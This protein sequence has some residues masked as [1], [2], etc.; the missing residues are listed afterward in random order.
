[1]GIV[2][3]NQE[4]LYFNKDWELAK[5]QNIPM[6]KRNIRDEKYDTFVSYNSQDYDN[7]LVD[8][9]NNIFKQ[10]NIKTYIDH[11]CNRKFDTNDTQEVKALKDFLMETVVCIPYF[12]ILMTDKVASQYVSWSLAEYSY[13][14][15]SCYLS[16]D[17]KK[18]LIPIIYLIQEGNEIFD[19]PDIFRDGHT[20]T[21][22]YEL[23]NVCK[24]IQNKKSLKP[25]ISSNIMD[26]SGTGDIGDNL[27][28]RSKSI[29]R[30]REDSITSGSGK[31][32]VNWY[33]A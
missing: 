18:G 15:L 30:M 19:L 5:A 11:K 31:F 27:I 26:I 22:D 12:C 7:G 28:E 25:F 8:R 23:K 14:N 29:E 21:N 10:Y 20:I 4:K 3:N 1:M 32:L 6:V 17:N 33:K 9:I 13:Y 2:N 24:D 16:Q